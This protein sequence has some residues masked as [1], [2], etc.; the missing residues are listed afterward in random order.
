MTCSFVGCG[1]DVS[2]DVD[3]ILGGAAKTRLNRT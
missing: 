2:G 1:G 3:P